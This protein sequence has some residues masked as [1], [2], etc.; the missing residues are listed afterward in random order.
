MPKDRIHEWITPSIDH[1]QLSTSTWAFW[2]TTSPLYHSNASRWTHFL[3]LAFHP[4]STQEQVASSF[5]SN[6]YN[7]APVIVS[8]NTSLR[9]PEFY[10]RKVGLRPSTSYTTP[11]L[12][13][14]SNRWEQR[15]EARD[16]RMEKKRKRRRKIGGE[17]ENEV[18]K[19][20][21]EN[22]GKKSPTW[23]YGAWRW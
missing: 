9:L 6:Q 5:R 3:V 8:L 12:A 10:G 13:T 22:S 23:C 7:P 14:T 17:E 4:I 21:K 15:E 18:E 16:R 19:K 2:Q 11:T 1:K 20:E